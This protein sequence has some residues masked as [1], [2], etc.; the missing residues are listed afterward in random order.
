MPQLLEMLASIMRFWPRSALK[1]VEQKMTTWRH[2]VG[3]AAFAVLAE[4][5]EGVRLPLR[6]TADAV[7]GLTASL[8][9]RLALLELARTAANDVLGA[10]P[11]GA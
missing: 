2:A 8:S 5:V 1:E 11:T 9:N 3:E 7:A 4:D 6:E 10:P